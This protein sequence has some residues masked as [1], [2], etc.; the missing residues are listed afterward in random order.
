MKKLFSAIALMAIS[1]AALVADDYIVLIDYSTS[2]SKADQKIYKKTLGSTLGKLGGGDRVA[3]VNIG[4]SDVTN[5]DFFEEFEMEKGSTNK[6]K[7]HNK[8]GLQ[9]LW[10]N[11]LNKPFETEN[12]TRIL[13]AVRGSAQRF[14][15]S[16]HDEKYLIVLSDMID[17]TGEANADEFATNKNCS[18]VST[19]VGKID[20]PDLKG[21][22]VYVAG[23]GG[24]GDAGYKCLESFWKEFFMQSGVHASD[25]VYQHINPFK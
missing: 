3:L 18:S 20:K 13:S 4:K 12:A 25:I 5:F 15:N 11:F 2:I 7:L 14:R 9:K 17:S 23:A 22:K 19:F 21:V 16:D 6:I 8:K 24:E 1:N 10:K